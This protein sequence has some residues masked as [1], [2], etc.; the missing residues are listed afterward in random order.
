MRETENRA[1]LA[2]QPKK[3]G[4]SRRSTRRRPRRCATRPTRLESALGHEVRVRPAKGEEIAVEIR[5]EDLDQALE[6][7]RL[8]AGELGRADRRHV[9]IIAAPAGD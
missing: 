2:S 3:K 4:G 8:E 7:A 9:A 1:K 5:L 6:L